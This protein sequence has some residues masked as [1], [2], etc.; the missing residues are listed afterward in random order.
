MQA[1]GNSLLEESQI[2]YIQY[3]RNSVLCFSTPGKKATSVTENALMDAEQ[4]VLDTF[5]FLSTE[6]VDMDDDDENLRYGD[7]L[8]RSSV[9][10]VTLFCK[11]CLT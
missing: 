10:Y 6:N 9:K 11:C 4:S 5:D 3:V 1:C 2:N 7:I 8:L